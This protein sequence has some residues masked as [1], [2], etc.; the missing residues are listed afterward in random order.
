MRRMA[1]QDRSGATIKSINAQHVHPRH[2]G[3]CGIRL[4]YDASEQGIVMKPNPA[5]AVVPWVDVL[6]IDRLD[7]SPAA[8][9]FSHAA[10]P[11][12]IHGSRRMISS[13]FP[14]FAAR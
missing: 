1:E 13:E 7:G 3:S 14:G 10:H 8:I 12:I 6:S 5:G 9:L 11:V 2:Y 4:H